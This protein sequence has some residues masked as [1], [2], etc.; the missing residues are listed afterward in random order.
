M[1]YGKVIIRGQDDYIIDADGLNYNVVP[2]SI[3]PYNTYDI[4]DVKAYIQDHPEMVIPAETYHL[5]ESARLA[6]LDR[7]FRINEVE[8]RVRRYQDET[9]LGLTP[10]DDIVKIVTYIQALR[11]IPQQLG[12]PDNI[13]W[14]VLEENDE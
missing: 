12:F 2:K 9:I 4:N 11:D 3:D 13:I 1:T 10:T 5:E 8:W 14:P 7:D 6:R